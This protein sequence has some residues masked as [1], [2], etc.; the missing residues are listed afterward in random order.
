VVTTDTP[1][2]CTGMARIFDAT[3]PR[4]HEQARAIC[5]TCPLIDACRGR[6]REAQRSA[7][8]AYGPEGTWAGVLLKA[9]A[10]A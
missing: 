5:A 1:P 7:M 4:S 3:D 2:P 6:L 10:I 8:P 9:K